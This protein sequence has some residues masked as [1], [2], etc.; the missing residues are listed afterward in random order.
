MCWMKEEEAWKLIREMEAV[1]EVLVENEKER[2]RIYKE[3]ISSRDPKRLIRIMKTMYLRRQKRLRDGK[4]STA[5]DERYFKLAE[6]HL[7][8]ELA[9]SLGI[10]KSEVNKIIE[11]N[12]KET[13]L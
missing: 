5:M 10:Q 12:I 6:N 7:Y 4:K 2:E 11:E 13:I 8:S 9:F 3:A 1:D